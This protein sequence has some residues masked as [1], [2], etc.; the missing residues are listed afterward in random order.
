M[1]KYKSKIA[2]FPIS[3]L[4]VFG[5]GENDLRDDNSLKW[6]GEKVVARMTT[7][8]LVRKLILLIS[9]Q[10]FPFLWGQSV[11]SE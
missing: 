2:L 8:K 11:K 7:L 9:F 10:I 5:T 4:S 3:T 6:R 1:L